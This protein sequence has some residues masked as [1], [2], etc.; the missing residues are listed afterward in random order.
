MKWRLSPHPSPCFLTL[1][2]WHVFI[3]VFQSSHLFKEIVFILTL[4]EGV[5]AHPLLGWHELQLSS[6]APPTAA[7]CQCRR[8]SGPSSCPVQ[9]A[10][11]SLTPAAT[12]PSAWAAHTPCA[13]RACTSYTARP[14]PSTRQPS[15]PTSTC[16]QSTVPCCSWS[17]LRCVS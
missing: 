7:G 1:L 9:Y 6:A 15:A 17:A 2:N 4:T 12:S 14:A 16:C 13:R 3:D 8:P 11:M 5:D 10:T